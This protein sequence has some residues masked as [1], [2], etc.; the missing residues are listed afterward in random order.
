[1]LP[2]PAQCWGQCTFEE[3]HSEWFSYHICGRCLSVNLRQQQGALQTAGA[4]L[5][6][7]MRRSQ[8]YFQKFS[9]LSRDFGKVVR[10]LNTCSELILRVRNAEL[11]HLKNRL[12]PGAPRDR[13]T[14]PQMIEDLLEH[15]KSVPRLR[16]DR[17]ILPDLELETRFRE[18]RQAGHA[19]LMSPESSGDDIPPPPIIPG[20]TTQ[21]GPGG[22]APVAAVA[23]AAPAAV[24][25]APLQYNPLRS[26][27]KA[28]PQQP[29]IRPTE[30]ADA[31]GL[32]DPWATEG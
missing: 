3:R 11:E 16:P 30:L 21:V 31:E 13:T 24:Y 19:V 5:T 4:G 2:P 15:L 10:Y 26:P 28:P 27:V 8:R 20:V 1:M 29:P 12:I 25:N 17:S 32:P 7:E 22:A 18:W 9:R 23:K 14:K 6:N